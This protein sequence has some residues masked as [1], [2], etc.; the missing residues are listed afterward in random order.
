MS[1]AYHPNL[2]GY[3]ERSVLH[4][5]CATCEERANN[6]IQGLLYLDGSVQRRLYR[7]MLVSEGK[8]EGER[9]GED[10]ISSRCDQLMTRALYHLAVLLERSGHDPWREDFLGE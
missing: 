8:L 9:L 6:G 3:D 2:E 5:G 10:A 4:D 1:H 7:K